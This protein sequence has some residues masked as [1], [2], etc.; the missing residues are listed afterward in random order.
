[1][2]N[3]ENNSRC[4]K[5]PRQTEKFFPKPARHTFGRGGRCASSTKQSREEVRYG[6]RRF[7]L[8]R[9]AGSYLVAGSPTPAASVVLPLGVLNRWR[10]GRMRRGVSGNFSRPELRYEPPAQR[11][12]VI[13]RPSVHS[14]VS[15]MLVRAQFALL[16][17]PLLLLL[18]RHYAPY[19]PPY[20]LPNHL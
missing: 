4:N 20:I 6:S 13:L 19:L 3:T 11:Q 15:A 8:P 18:R 12:S 17:R 1:M 14:R 10:C 2:Q 9:G 16:S 5:N 7:T